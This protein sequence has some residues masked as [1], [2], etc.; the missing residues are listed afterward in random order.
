MSIL[1]GPEP[2]S[3]SGFEK[4]K[5]KTGQNRTMAALIVSH[6]VLWGKDSV[7]FLIELTSL[8]SNQNLCFTA[9]GML[10]CK[11]AYIQVTNK[12]GMITQNFGFL[13]DPAGFPIQIQPRF[14]DSL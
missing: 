6:V 7:A 8:C 13:I 4:Y 10:A 11:A 2:W 12:I 5:V 14:S 3:G 1:T 9:A